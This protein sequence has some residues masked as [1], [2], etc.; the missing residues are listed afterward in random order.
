MGGLACS[1]VYAG[2]ASAGRPVNKTANTP[3][4]HARASFKPY[5][6]YMGLLSFKRSQPLATR[7]IIQITLAN[8]M[9]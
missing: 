1:T 5:T 7:Q 9:A 3:N 6:S 4:A 8:I 2:C